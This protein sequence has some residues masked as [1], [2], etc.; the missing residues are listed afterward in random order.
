MQR[1]VRL[2]EAVATQ[3]HRRN[4]RRATF[5]RWWRRQLVLCPN[6]LCVECCR[7]TIHPSVATCKSAAR[8]EAAPEG[9]WAGGWAVPCGHGSTHTRG[10]AAQAGRRVLQFRRFILVA[11]SVNSRSFSHPVRSLN[12]CK[13]ASTKA[14][15][16]KAIEESRFLEMEERRQCSRAAGARRIGAGG[17]RRF[18]DERPGASKAKDE[19]EVCRWF[20]NL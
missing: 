15:R 16:A 12:Q 7:S 20:T 4:Q 18:A 9:G 5:E 19:K 1:P 3:W 6:L 10:P 17:G 14:P 8:E 13:N 2:T 11:F